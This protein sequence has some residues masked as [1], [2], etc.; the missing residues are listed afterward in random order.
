MEQ[1][2]RVEPKNNLAGKKMRPF[3]ILFCVV[4]SVN[5]CMACLPSVYHDVA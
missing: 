2:A 4:A 1:T 3:D 5:W